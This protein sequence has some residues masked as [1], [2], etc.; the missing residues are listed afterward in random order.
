[1][2][3]AMNSTRD[4]RHAAH[5]LD[6]GDAERPHRRQLRAPAERQQDRQ[7][8]REG[9][10]D[11]GRIR[12][13][14]RPLH[15]AGLDIGHAEHA[16]PHQHADDERGR[17][18][19]IR[20]SRRPHSRRSQLARISADEDHDDEERPPMLLVGEA[21]EQDEA[22]LL[23]DEGPAGAVSRARQAWPFGA[24]PDRVD[25]APSGPSAARSSPSRYDREQRQDRVEDAVEQIGAQPARAAPAS[26]DG[27][28]PLRPVNAA[29]AWTS[30]RPSRSS[31]HQRDG[32]GCRS[33]SAARSS[34]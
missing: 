12:V 17:P 21:A 20:A 27:R 23:D 4:Q 10:A 18:T 28:R 6:I 5:Q 1:M 11:H 25:E 34:G 8:K 16:A 32:R 14:G 19:Q 24:A 33:S 29:V 30:A 15:S 31:L 3:E 26:T 7:R 9:H 13:S 2:T 22:Q